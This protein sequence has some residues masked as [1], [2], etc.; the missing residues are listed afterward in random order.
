MP[1]Y[2]SRQYD[3]KRVFDEVEQIL[4]NHKRKS[5]RTRGVD[6]RGRDYMDIEIHGGKFRIEVDDFRECVRVYRYVNEKNRKFE[7]IDSL[8]SAHSICFKLGVW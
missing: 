5:V 8:N 6:D 1:T 4:K 7:Y 3:W 2:G